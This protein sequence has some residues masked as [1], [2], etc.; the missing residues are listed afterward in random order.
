MIY[1][2][3]YVSILLFMC[4]SI[5]NITNAATKIYVQNNTPF[6]YSIDVQQTGNSLRRNKWRA[7]AT[8][9]LP[10]QRAMVLKFNRDSGIKNGRR[11]YFNTHLTV[12]DVYT[13]TL[14]QQ[15]KGLLVNSKLWHSLSGENFSHAW[16]SDRRPHNATLG[17]R[18]IKVTYKAYFTGTDDNV[19]YVLHYDDTLP[20]VSANDQISRENPLRLDV[21]SYNVYMRPT[22]VFKNGQKV[23]AGIIPH[24]ITGYDA[25]V[26]QEAFDD[27]SRSRLLGMLRN[28]YPHK[29]KVIGHDAGTT[30]DGGIL[31]LSRWP[32]LDAKERKFDYICEGIDCFSDKGIVYAKISKKGVPYHIFGTHF[33]ANYHRAKMQQARI[34][35]DFIRSRNIPANEAVVVAGDFNINSLDETTN[36]L[37]DLLSKAN[38]RECQLVGTMNSFNPKVNDLNN[39]KDIQQLDH[40]LYSQSHKQP[41]QSFNAVR[42]LRSETGWKEYGFEG[43]RWDLSDH[44]PVHGHFVFPE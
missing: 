44:Y 30:Q 40:V 9:V 11:Y 17:Y 15:V 4:F 6:S 24:K 10:G 8:P 2:Y 43:E 20:K 28:V 31:I 14:K 3:H 22:T 33:E 34:L 19:E 13:F 38:L 12:D 25:V 39:E 26:L 29:T 36:G 32:I 7:R 37:N 41:V 27:E 16:R 23:R 5:P 35:G 21:L 18:D 42:L 1:K